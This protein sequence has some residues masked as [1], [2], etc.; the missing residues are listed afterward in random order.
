MPQ[1]P[2]F[3]INVTWVDTANF[4]NIVDSFADIEAIAQMSKVNVYFFY[5]IQFDFDICRIY[6]V[7]CVCVY[8]SKTEIL[9][10]SLHNINSSRLMFT[11]NRIDGNSFCAAMTTWYLK[12]FF[13]CWLW[14]HSSVVGMKWVIA[15]SRYFNNM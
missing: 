14:F 3:S 12:T 13:F 15:N 2:A 8:F 11:H 7:L 10:S 6:C 9:F 4:E 5:W 1:H